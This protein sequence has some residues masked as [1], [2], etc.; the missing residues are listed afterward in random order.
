MGTVS[1]TP[2]FIDMA[3]IGANGTVTDSTKQG[4]VLHTIALISIILVV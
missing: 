2:G 4:C 3:K 1:T